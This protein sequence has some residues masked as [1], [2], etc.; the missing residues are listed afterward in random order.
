LKLGAYVMLLSNLYDDEGRLVYVNGDCATVVEHSPYSLHVRLV[1]NGREVKVEW[2]TR[3][4]GRKDKP[5]NWDHSI[6][7]GSYY[8]RPHWYAK[9]RRY[10]EGQVQYAPLRLAYASTVHKSQG[11]S[12]DRAQIDIR[13]PFF[14]QPAMLYVALSRCRT[15]QGL[16][17]V[18]Q[19]E[20]Y[21][22]NCTVDERVRPWL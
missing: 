20:R 19:R 14:A 6:G 15:M 5:T 22:S 11:V 9:K 21:V 2:V 12:L 17:I 1:R 16:R 10:V 13:N 8:A 7:D 4:V 18:G 3:D